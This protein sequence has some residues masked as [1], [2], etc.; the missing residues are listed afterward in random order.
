MRSK[1]VGAVLA[2]SLRR[3]LPLPGRP[4]FPAMPSEDSAMP[5]TI[6]LP[7]PHRTGQMA[8]EDALEA[9]RS[10]REFAKGT[11]ELP[12]LG[13]LLWAG[14]GV[15]SPRGLRTAPSAAALYPLET[16][17]A[18]GDVAGL[19]AGVYHYLPTAH[20]LSRVVAGDRRG[21]LATASLG[22]SWMARAPV[23]LLIASVLERLAR[24]Y[25]ERASLYLH[26][27][28]GCA[29]QNVALQAVSLGLGTVMVGAF[30]DDAVTEA[31]ALRDGERPLVL[32]PVGRH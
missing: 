28:A 21:A 14:Q 24:R 8:L 4:A 6:T 18:V 7:T 17:V 20:A 29:A 10:V 13:Q 3:I 19:A 15:T 9:R 27:E 31:A 1:K 16:Y 22:Q 32:L 30:D 2:S 5:D 12:V 11:L 26:L 23:I 25:G